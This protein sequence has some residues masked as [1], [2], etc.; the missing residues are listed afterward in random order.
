MRCADCG[1][2]LVAE[3]FCLKCYPSLTGRA[4]P[5]LVNKV[6]DVTRTARNCLELALKQSK[7]DTVVHKYF[8]ALFKPSKGNGPY[9]VDDS[10]Y[11]SVDRILA[12]PEGNRRFATIFRRGK[13]CFLHLDIDDTRAGR[14]DE[15]TTV[16]S[17]LVLVT[18][19]M[20]RVCGKAPSEKEWLVS[21]CDRREKTSVHADALAVPFKDITHCGNLMQHYKQFVEMIM[22]KEDHESLEEAKAVCWVGDDSRFHHAVD[23]SIYHHNALLKLPYQQKPGRPPMLPLQMRGKEITDKSPRADVILAA[24]AHTPALDETPEEALVTVHSRPTRPRIRPVRDSATGPALTE[25]PITSMEKAA[26]ALIE[27]QLK[28]TA[29]C[30]LSMSYSGKD[31]AG[32]S[33]FYVKYDGA[34]RC[35]LGKHHESNNARVVVGGKKAWFYC[36][37]AGC[38]QRFKLPDLPIFVGRAPAVL[39]DEQQDEKKVCLYID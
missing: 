32:R 2:E 16:Q 13:P 39:V 17:A 21:S 1:T 8:S 15:S 22:G 33:V 28:D 27:G 38:Q 30:N 18:E 25:T 34:H 7:S 26:M 24:L 11:V 4:H 12:A 20:K 37:S 9:L 5:Y 36:F 31:S 29:G 23:F 6:G 3:A 19:V 35:A 14:P 10:V